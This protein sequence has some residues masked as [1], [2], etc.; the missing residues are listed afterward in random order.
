MTGLGSV[1]GKWWIRSESDPR[2]NREGRGEVGG[3]YKRPPAVDRTIKLL[4]QEL[5]DPPND[6]EW[7]YEKDT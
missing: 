3:L 7:G 1:L 6:L 2:W 4:R 5:G